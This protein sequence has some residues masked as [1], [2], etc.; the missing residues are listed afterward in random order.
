MKNNLINK[1]SE[2]IEHQVNEDLVTRWLD[3]IFNRVKKQ[4]LKNSPEY[5]STLSQLGDTDKEIKNNVKQLKKISKTA[6]KPKTK[7]ELRQKLIDMGIEPD[8]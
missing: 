1:L 4:K 6:S 2:R 5:Q 3:G 7:E 8:F